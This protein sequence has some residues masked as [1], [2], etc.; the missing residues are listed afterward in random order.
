MTEMALSSPSLP[1]TELSNLR[2]WIRL[3]KEMAKNFE[4][5]CATAK[6]CPKLLH[7]AAYNAFTK[8]TA[9]TALSRATC[10]TVLL[11]SICLFAPAYDLMK[12]L[13]SIHV[14]P[15]NTKG[16]LKVSTTVK[17]N[18]LWIMRGAYSTNQ[19]IKRPPQELS[20]SLQKSSKNSTIN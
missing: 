3:T 11:G 2:A 6:D 13:D 14:T 15:K 18:R 5:L 7:A 10:I 8:E 4:W 16:S 20:N 17:S 19:I 1:H 12:Q 9:L